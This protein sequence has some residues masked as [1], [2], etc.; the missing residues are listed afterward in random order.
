V[1][2]KSLNIAFTSLVP[3]HAINYQPVRISAVTPLQ[4]KLQPSQIKVHGKVAVLEVITSMVIKFRLT[5]ILAKLR[6]TKAAFG[7]HLV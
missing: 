5:Y 7:Q 4:A 1:T 2:H 3:A 6:T